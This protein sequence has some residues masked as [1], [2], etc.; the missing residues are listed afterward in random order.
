M[1]VVDASVLVALLTHDD[2]SPVVARLGRSA[3]WHAPVTVDA[4]VLHALRRQ[5]VADVLSAKAADQAVIAF[6]DIP[7]TR[8][9]VHPLVPR[10]WQLRQNV[11]AYDAAYI[12]L[13]ET[14]NLPLVT[15]DARLAR[16]SGHNATVDLL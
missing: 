14:L 11:T 3:E 9:P 4:E 7:I 12:A 1:I 5:W 15:R 13:A 10:M 8:H 6:H 16:S 2:V